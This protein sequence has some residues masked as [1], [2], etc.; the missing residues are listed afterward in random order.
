M[1]VLV[2]KRLVDVLSKGHATVLVPLSHVASQLFGLVAAVRVKIA[3]I[4]PIHF[5]GVL[6]V[7]RISDT[8]GS[9]QLLQ[10]GLSRNVLGTNRVA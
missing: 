8:N 3:R 6:F 4:F 10:F 5:A 7:V 1:L 9:F 2:G